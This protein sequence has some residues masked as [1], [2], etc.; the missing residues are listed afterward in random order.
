MNAFIN[1]LVEANL[2]L[3]LFLLLYWALL[4]KETDFG[5]KRMFL[6]MSIGVSLLF[7]FF[8][9]TATTQFVPALVPTRWLPE[10]VVYG[11]SL[12]PK[13][14]NANFD[15]WQ[16]MRLVYSGGVVITLAAFLWQLITVLRMIRRAPSYTRDRLTILESSDSLSSFSFFRFIFI[17]K[18][19]LLSD[20]EKQ[21]IIDHER[22]HAK[23][24]HSIDVILTNV[25][26]ILFWFNPVI[27]IYKKIFVHLHE[28]EADARAVKYH[29]VNDYCSLLAKVALL[30]AD[31]KIANHFSN[32][33]TLKR[34]EMMRTF[35]SKIRWWKIAALAAAIPL[36]FFV[37]ACQDQVAN[38]MTNIARNANVALMAPE[39]VV[40]RYEEVKKANPNSTYLLVEFNEAGDKLLEEM[41]TKHGIPKSIELFTPDNGV[42][43]NSTMNTEPE[44]ISFNQSKEW[45]RDAKNG[46]L[47]TFA[48]IEYN[49]MAQQI[50]ERASVDEIY[51]IVD[52]SAQPENGMEELY[53]NVMQKLTYPA[54][55]RRM[56]IE[57]K[58]WV[59]FVVEKDGSITDL[60][61]IKGIGG[62][63]DEA[64]IVVLKTS[65]VKWIPGKN[66]GVPVKQRMVMPINFKLEGSTLKDEAKNPD[67]SVEEVVVSGRSN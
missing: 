59:E 64:A 56:G 43:K 3:C 24:L 23:R 2:G 19:H 52:E 12:K 26:G 40:A 16:I 60:K 62:G 37:V 13:E 30:S 53:K 50:V 51:N 5:V 17:G 58:V 11:E 44:K 39:S 10:V 66:K 4:R 49:D 57:G 31:F 6:L 1:Y 63:C 15:T 65:L 38:D 36:Y 61:A 9:F 21:L 20:A 46:D 35:K 33:L 28:Y 67:N 32:S 41:E 29:D 8:H 47:R 7:P 25:M 34:I 55:A 22:I 54:Q 27:R 45:E 48:I 14:A 42:Y 18:S